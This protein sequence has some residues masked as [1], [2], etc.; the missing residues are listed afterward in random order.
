[1]TEPK[2]AG[3]GAAYA[4]VFGH[5]DVVAAYRLRPPYP[6]ETIQALAALAKG[7]AVLDAGCGTGELARRLAPLAERVDAVDVSAAMLAEGRTLPSGDAANLRW[8]H[9]SIEEALLEPPC[10]LAVAGDCSHWF[11][12][13]SAMPRLREVLADHGVPGG[14]ASRLAAERCAAEHDWHYPVSRRVMWMRAQP[15][16]PRLSASCAGHPRPESALR[17]SQLAW[18]EVLS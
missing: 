11:D 2:P 4:A 18:T 5:D 12:W 9:G 14:R 3:W 6:E 1:V 7:G 16:S 15:D 17:R 8:V 13:P 10:A